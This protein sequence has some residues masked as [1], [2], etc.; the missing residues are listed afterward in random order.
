MKAT[1]LGSHHVLVVFHTT[2]PETRGGIN[3]MIGALAH[4]WTRQGIRVSLFAP[5]PWEQKGLSVERFGSITL[6]KM[7][8]RPYRDSR[9]PLRGLLG[10]LAELPVTLW[11]LHRLMRRER[12]DVVHFHTPRDYQ[13]VFQLLSL[14]GGPPGVLT[15]HGT[16]ALDFAR[17]GPNAQGM[18]RWIVGRMAALTAVARHYARQIEAAHPGLAPVRVIPNGIPPI[19]EE[20]VEPC[21]VDLPQRFWVMVGWI[22][23]PKAQDVAVRAWGEVL[24]HDRDVHLVIV[25][26]QPFVQP[27]RPYYPGFFE[28]VRQLAQDQGAGSRIHWVGSLPRGQVL[29]VLQRAQGLIFPTHREG[30]PYVLLEAGAVGLPVVCNRIPPFT[31]LL[32][33]DRTGVLTPDSDHLALAEAVLR[34]EA[35]PARRRAMGLAWREQVRREYSR[36]AMAEGY[37]VLFREL[38]G[39]DFGRDRREAGS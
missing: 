29:S 5:A 32:E 9:R 36:E 17:N 28:Q 11:R 39:K 30:M 13:C 22:E 31:D 35:D 26:D 6:Y 7:R 20:S 24:K 10:F 12:V 27:G 19:E 4:A 14:L 18:L 33:P 15:F 37:L 25:G 2:F 1:S 23:P 21:G 8:L 3:V 38:T 16:D 34:L